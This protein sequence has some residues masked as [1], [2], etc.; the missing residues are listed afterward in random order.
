MKKSKS[1]LFGRFI[2]CGTC[3]TVL[4]IG[5]FALKSPPYI[6]LLLWLLRYVWLRW[7]CSK[8]IKDAKGRLVITPFQ[9]VLHGLIANL[10]E[11]E[12]SIG[13]SM[14]RTRNEG[15]RIARTY[16]SFFGLLNIQKRIRGT[17][18]TEEETTGAL[19]YV[20]PKW[21]E[22]PELLLQHLGGHAVGKTN[23]VKE[24]DILYLVDY[25]DSTGNDHMSMSSM[26]FSA[27]HYCQRVK[28]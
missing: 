17:H 10:S 3:R 25:G 26:L 27:E 18:P 28:D 1:P 23:W 6:S 16:F 4:L 11:V 24:G 8:S 22:K 13:C 15:F 19:R 7:I 9:R 5:P 12:V 14:L 2:K 20:S 21:V